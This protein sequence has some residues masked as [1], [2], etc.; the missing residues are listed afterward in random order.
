MDTLPE[1]ILRRIFSLAGCGLNVAMINRRCYDVLKSEIQSIQLKKVKLTV[2]FL[3]WVYSVIGD[4][5]FEME[6][7]YMHD[8]GLIVFCHEHNRK[9]L[10]MALESAKRGYLDQTRWC[11]EHG[12]AWHPDI[13]PIALSK[14]REDLLYFEN[15][16]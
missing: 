8:I 5:M 9:G 4:R 16:I 15:N 10:N 1:E 13:R 11:L 3:E 12:F 2:E 14:N 7:E 6:F